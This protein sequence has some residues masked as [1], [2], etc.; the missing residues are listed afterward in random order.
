MSWTQDAVEKAST[1]QS[2][3]PGPQLSSPGERERNTIMAIRVGG[4]YAAVLFGL[5]LPFTHNPFK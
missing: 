1:Q 3:S 2:G 5:Q 4:Q